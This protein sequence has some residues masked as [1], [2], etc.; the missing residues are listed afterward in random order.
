MIPLP[1][2]TDFSCVT[3]VY[4]SAGNLEHYLFMGD[5]VYQAN[6]LGA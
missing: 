1:P 4:D 2:I 6:Y 5:T 3:A